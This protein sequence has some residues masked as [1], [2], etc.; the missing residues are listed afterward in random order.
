MF[1]YDYIDEDWENKLKEKKLPDIKYFDSSL[2]KTKC[3][4]YDYNYAEEV[5]KY[6][7]CKEITDY[8]DLY[9]KTDVLLLANVFTSYRK[10]MHE[11]YGL[12][13]LYCISAPGFSNRAML[14]ITNIEIKLITSVDMHLIIQHGIRVGKCELIYYHAKANNKYVSPDFNKDNE[15]QSYIISLDANS[16]MH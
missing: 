1:P 15:K 4:T 7:N 3:P 11:I 8:S 12:D 16:L 13:P 9:V 14:K 2:N 6:F 10:N 5:Y